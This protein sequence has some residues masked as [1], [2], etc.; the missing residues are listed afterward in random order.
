M[1]PGGAGRRLVRKRVLVEDRR[2]IGAPSHWS[3]MD[4]DDA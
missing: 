3:L 2:S 1:D 4:T